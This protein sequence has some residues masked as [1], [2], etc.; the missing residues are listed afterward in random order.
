MIANE[1]LWLREIVSEHD[2]ML[3]PCMNLYTSAF[4]PDERIPADSFA[5][6]LQRRA[7]GEETLPRRHRRLAVALLGDRFAGFCSFAGM[8]DQQASAL[9]QY[10]ALFYMAVDPNLRARGIGGFMFGCVQSML[11]TDAQWCGAKAMGLI[12]EVE[13]P[14]T[15]A[16]AKVRDLRERRI[17]FYE[18]LGCR[19]L[20]RIDYLQPAV[21]AD[22]APLRLHLMATGEVASRADR[23]V[24]RMWYRLIFGLGPDDPT[25]AA[26]MAD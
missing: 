11:A 19:L 13:R 20:K 9:E 5:Q 24:C 26:A 23:H 1:R 2:P 3:G 17:K 22:H 4:P 6:A 12:L 10:G 25:V 15:A 21:D 18:R 16:D 14:D 7:H 8:I